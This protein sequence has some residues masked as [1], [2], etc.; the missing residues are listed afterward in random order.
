MKRKQ[1]RSPFNPMYLW[2]HLVRLFLSLIRPWCPNHTQASYSRIE[3][4]GSYVK[5][6]EILGVIKRPKPGIFSISCFILLLYLCLHRT[7]SIPFRAYGEWFGVRA[8]AQVPYHDHHSTHCNYFKIHWFRWLVILHSI[9][10]VFGWML[11]FVCLAVR[12]FFDY[13]L[14]LPRAT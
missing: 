2:A 8:I 11:L 3:S 9:R 4:C 5:E 13:S 14:S 7:R 12:Y 1:Y 6:M 10:I